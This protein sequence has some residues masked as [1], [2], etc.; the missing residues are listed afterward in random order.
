MYNLL[1]NNIIQQ[2]IHIIALSYFTIEQAKQ[3]N[4][5]VLSNTNNNNTQITIN[6]YINTTDNIY[7]QL[8]FQHSISGSWS[9]DALIMYANQRVQTIQK[10]N[11]ST[12]ILY[13][14]Q[15]IM[16]TL[17]KL[18]NH[19]SDL[20][21]LGGDILVDQQCNIKMIYYSKN[22]LDRPSIDYIISCIQ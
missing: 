1:S 11:Q 8:G 15:S 20:E 14:L 22:S 10:N 5:I 6:H 7:Q 3:W 2:N 21:Q 12:S 4:R 13:K 19:N 18:F 17:Y 16:N 9:L